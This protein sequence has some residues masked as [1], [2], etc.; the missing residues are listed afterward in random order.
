MVVP[1]LQKR[2]NMFAAN[3]REINEKLKKW[4]KLLGEHIMHKFI[5]QFITCKGSGITLSSL[6]FTGM[7]GK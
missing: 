7:Q 3:S 2:F 1:M 5:I 4:N 6:V